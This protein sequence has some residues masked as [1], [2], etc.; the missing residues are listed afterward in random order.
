MKCIEVEEFEEK[1]TIKEIEEIE[2]I[3]GIKLPYAY[4]KHLLKYNGGHPVNDCYPLIDHILSCNILTHVKTVSCDAQISWFY[5]IYNGEYENF[6]REYKIFSD[7]LP[8]GLIPIGRGAGGDLICLSVDTKTYGKVYFWDRENEAPE[9]EEPWWDNVF[10]I[11]N[12]FTDFINSLYFGDVEMKINGNIGEAIKYVYIHDIYSLPYYI[13][14]GRKYC[15]LMKGFFAKAPIEVEE[16]T[17][18]KVKKTSDL[19]L[20]YEVA[21]QNKRYI[22]TITDKTGEYNDTEENIA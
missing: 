2:R 9:G 4:I 19:I 11:A 22:R 10:L 16:F 12:S 6:L 8:K 18:E 14:N 3:I 20:K 1:I 21:S 17:V 13:N 5:A 15:E 7:R